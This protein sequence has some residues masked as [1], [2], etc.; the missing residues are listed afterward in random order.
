[1]SSLVHVGG[2]AL[3]GGLVWM[4][5]RD[6]TGRRYFAFQRARQLGAGM[7]AE[8]ARQVGFATVEGREGAAYRGVAAAA[9]IIARTVAA[10]EGQSWQ[11]LVACED[12]QFLV[13]QGKGSE[14]LP[15]GDRVYVGEAPAREACAAKTDWDTQWATPGLVAGARE[16]VL[17]HG[18]VRGADLARL[19]AV[20]FGGIGAPRRTALLGT[21][22]LGVVA[23]FFWFNSFESTEA[24]VEAAAPPEAPEPVWVA[25]G[26]PPGPFV[27]RCLE[28]QAAY[29]PVLPQMWRLRN[30]GCYADTSRRH[31]L[32][33]LA[34]DQGA[35]V[36]TWNA[37][38]EANRALARRIAER[39]LNLWPKGQVVGSKAWAAVRFKRPMRTWEGEAPRAAEFRRAVDRALAT[40]SEELRFTYADGMSFE[41]RT[42]LALGELGRRLEGIGWLDMHEAVWL[43]GKW[44]LKGGLVQRRLLA[45][46]DEG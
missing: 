35:M 27:A 45:P 21:A 8:R 25:Q 6:E 18:E 30:L 10:P 42:G 31:E 13:V 1:M 11:A 9:D 5:V 19:R 15:E 26:V 34:L 14:M 43:E 33:R 16:L 24:Y 38:P 7:Y 12:D 40:V 44:T 46:E 4:P 29:P 22:L 23:A 41:A 28:A 3:A 32:S 36:A 37:M 39:R 20:P 2:V 17:G